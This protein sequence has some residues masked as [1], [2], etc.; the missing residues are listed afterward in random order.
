VLAEQGIGRDPHRRQVELARYVP[1]CEALK[2]VG[3]RRAQEHVAVPSREGRSA[4]VEAGWS[5]PSADDDESGTEL[6][7]ERLRQAWQLG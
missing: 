7:R 4:G 6:T 3:R 2:R 1:R 5:E